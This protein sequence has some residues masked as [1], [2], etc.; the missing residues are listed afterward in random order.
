MVRHVFVDWIRYQ[1]A[2]VHRLSHQKLSLS[3]RFCSP[4]TFMWKN[5]QVKH[6]D[7]FFPPYLKNLWEPFPFS[8][9]TLE[10]FCQGSDADFY[11]L[12]VKFSVRGRKLLFCV[13]SLR[14]KL[15]YKREVF[16]VAKLN[17]VNILCSPISN[18]FPSNIKHNIWFWYL[19]YFT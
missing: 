9:E 8:L 12:S 11:I 16:S 15:K 2:V 13:A 19:L 4:A 18:T 14:N 17:D 3:A 6:L 7:G 1:V 10:I 5:L